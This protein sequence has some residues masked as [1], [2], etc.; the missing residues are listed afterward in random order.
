MRNKQI[1]RIIASK[2]DHWHAR[3]WLTTHASQRIIAFE[4]LFNRRHLG[5]H[6]VEDNDKFLYA[7][8][9]FESRCRQIIDDIESGEA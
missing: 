4:N 6:R 1:M 5:L 2:T 9:L 7:Y 8:R 3:D